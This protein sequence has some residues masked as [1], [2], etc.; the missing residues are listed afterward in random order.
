VKTGIL[1][2][3]EGISPFIMM[4]EFEVFVLA[5]MPFIEL[6]GAIPFGALFLDLPFW[7]IFLISIL[8]NIFPI[9]FILIFLEKIVEFLSKRSQFFRVFFE[10]LFERTRKRFAPLRKKY[11]K[12]ALVLFVAL[13]FPLSGA[14]SGSLVAF[15]F[16]FSFKLAFFLISLGVLIA[17]GIVSLLVFKGIQIEKYFG[18]Q[19]LLVLI[20][21][22][23]LIY[24][25]FSLLKKFRKK[26]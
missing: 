25:G 16:G 14:W 22:I 6:R 1:N 13:P 19:G 24:F 2:L 15:L 4:P 23:L 18:W 9:I 3:N 20:L 11:G 21:I 10:W 7:K 5:M 17:G 8:G 26:C 12:S